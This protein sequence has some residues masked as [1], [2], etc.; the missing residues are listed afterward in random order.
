[1]WSVATFL[2]K[3]F[4]SILFHSILGAP[5]VINRILQ[6]KISMSGAWRS[7]AF[8]AQEDVDSVDPG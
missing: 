8:T 6:M 7:I 1:M 5:N 3:W 2:K 4:E